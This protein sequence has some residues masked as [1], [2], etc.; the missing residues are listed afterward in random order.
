MLLLELDHEISQC[1]SVKERVDGKLEGVGTWADARRLMAGCP[2]PWRSPTF[3]RGK[4]GRDWIRVQL[5]QRVSKPE[6]ILSHD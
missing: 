5:I 6:Q 3:R 1:L 4:R 2:P